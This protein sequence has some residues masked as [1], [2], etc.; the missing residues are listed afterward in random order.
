MEKSDG[1]F[2]VVTMLVRDV[3]EK[4]RRKARGYI[5][6][7]FYCVLI[8]RARER[9]K[10]DLIDLWKKSGGFFMVVAMLV[11]DVVEKV[12]GEAKGYIFGIFL[13]CS[14]CLC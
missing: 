11:R 6:G 4:M 14:Y 1:F 9:A 2:V 10:F 5:F 12:K 13:L 7:I 3:V 8:A